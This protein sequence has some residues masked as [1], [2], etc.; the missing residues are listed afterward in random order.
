M[1]SRHN[2]HGLKPGP[3]GIGALNLEHVWIDPETV[4]R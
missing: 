3:M 1:A 4:D 2:I